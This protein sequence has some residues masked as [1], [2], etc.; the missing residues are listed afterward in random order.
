[1]A[2]RQKKPWNP[3][4][5]IIGI[6]VLL[7]VGLSLHALVMSFTQKPVQNK[8]PS[9]QPIEMVKQ[10]IDTTVTP[11]QADVQPEQTITV[12]PLQNTISP[13]QEPASTES[14]LSTYFNWIYWYF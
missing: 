13:Q 2:P 12:S 14:S 5:V 11:S 1:M 9:P 3:L 8:P 4:L 6:V 10:T 7:M